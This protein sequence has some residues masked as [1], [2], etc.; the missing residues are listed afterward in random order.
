SFTA[1][2]APEERQKAEA[3]IDRQAHLISDRIADLEDRQRKL[4]AASSLGAIIS[5]VVHEGMQPAAYIATTVNRLRRFYP[6][7]LG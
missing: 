5:E 2:L 3:A 1:S 4:E 6:D 7:L